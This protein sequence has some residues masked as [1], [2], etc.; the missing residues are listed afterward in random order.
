MLSPFSLTEVELHYFNN[1]VLE[2]LCFSEGLIITEL[3][4]PDGFKRH[5]LNFEAFRLTSLFGVV[6]EYSVSWSLYRKLSVQFPPNIKFLWFTE[7]MSYSPRDK[8]HLVYG[9]REF[10]I[11][12]SRKCII[13]LLSSL[14]SRKTHKITLLN[15]EE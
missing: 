1:Y 9:T 14:E 2:E 12:Q 13:S 11:A 10:L 8:S 4:T 5:L 6:F 7:V 15:S 3:P